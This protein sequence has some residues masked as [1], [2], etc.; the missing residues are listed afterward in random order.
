MCEKYYLRLFNH[1]I[2][3]SLIEQ[4][5][6]PVISEFF[7]DIKSNLDAQKIRSMSRS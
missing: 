4:V 7:T 2:V 5:I 3:G 1:D 6:P